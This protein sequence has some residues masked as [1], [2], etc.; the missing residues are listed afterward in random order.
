MEFR[1]NASFSENETFI[2]IDGE[3]GKVKL[4]EEI[5]T[6]MT[7]EKLPFRPSIIVGDKASDDVTSKEKG[8][9]KEK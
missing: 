7:I 6:E 8:K 3:S 5:I 1:S 2:Q 9:E 4:Q